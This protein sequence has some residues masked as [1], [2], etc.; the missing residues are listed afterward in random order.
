MRG[1]NASDLVMWERTLGAP[2]RP[3]SS[4]RAPRSAGPYSPGCCRSAERPRRSAQI[5]R[6]SSGVAP[7][8]APARPQ[9]F[10]LR[11]GWHLERLTGIPLHPRHNSTLLRTRAA[12]VAA[13]PPLH[14]MR[15]PCSRAQ[16][17]TET[18]DFFIHQRPLSTCRLGPPGGS[19]N[20]SSALTCSSEWRTAISA[21][22]SSGVCCRLRRDF[23]RIP[24]LTAGSSRPGTA[25]RRGRSLWNRTRAPNFWW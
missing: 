7:Q 16:R 3:S 20:L 10:S 23:V 19:G 4:R 17:Y 12:M 6:H 18:R 11:D 15:R 8:D 5:A 1:S 9:G 24:S 21:R 2:R 14:L 13:A 22:L 25:E